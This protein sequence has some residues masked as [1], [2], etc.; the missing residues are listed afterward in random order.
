MCPNRLCQN[1]ACIF[2]YMHRAERMF[3]LSPSFFSHLHFIGNN[4]CKLS[5]CPYKNLDFEHIYWILSIYKGCHPGLN[6]AE[7]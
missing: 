7:I 1:S 2:F 6:Q 4:E 5:D 3:I